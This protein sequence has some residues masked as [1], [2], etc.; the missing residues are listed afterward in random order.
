MAVAMG[1]IKNL[2]SI[3][4]VAAQMVPVEAGAVV[5]VVVVSGHF[6]PLTIQTIAS[7]HIEEISTNHSDHESMVQVAMDIEARD[8]FEVAVKIQLTPSP[9]Q[10]LGNNYEEPGPRTV[11]LPLLI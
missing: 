4:S 10:L 3:V 7:L 9:P 2:A 8:H 5:E 6:V 11:Q 1:A